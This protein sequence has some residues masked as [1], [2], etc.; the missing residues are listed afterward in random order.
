MSFKEGR[1]VID[2]KM[3]QNEEIMDFCRKIQHVCDTDYDKES[4]DIVARKAGDVVWSN[5]PVD[6][7]S[8]I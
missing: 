2:T 7:N 1:I 8:K 5:T 6:A 3:M 4:L